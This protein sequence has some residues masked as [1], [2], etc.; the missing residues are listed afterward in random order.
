M[1]IGS[2]EGE[3]E[4]T[5]GEIK[6]GLHRRVIF[7]VRNAA[8]HIVRRER[9]RPGERQLRRVFCETWRCQSRDDAALRAPV[10]S[11]PAK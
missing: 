2:P 11:A 3:K 1:T 5:V 7:G 10:F 6:L 4:H 8:E 9:R